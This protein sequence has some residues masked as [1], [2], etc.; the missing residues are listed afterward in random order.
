M[1]K[2]IYRPAKVSEAKHFRISVEL[3]FPAFYR[4]GTIIRDRRGNLW[5]SW[6]DQEYDTL[7]LWQSTARVPESTADPKGTP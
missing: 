6:R 2:V 4:E 7:P 1:A 5:R 3:R